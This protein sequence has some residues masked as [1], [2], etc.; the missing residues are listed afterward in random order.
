M[1]EKKLIN[2]DEGS[3]ILPAHKS[4]RLAFDNMEKG[5]SNSTLFSD[6][7]HALFRPV[8]SV[9]LRAFTETSF[10]F[11]MSCSVLMMKQEDAW[12]PLMGKTGAA[13]IG[14]MYG[15]GRFISQNLDRICGHLAWPEEYKF[16][17]PSMEDFPV[18]VADESKDDINSFTIPYMAL[19]EEVDELPDAPSKVNKRLKC[20]LFHPIGCQSKVVPDAT[21]TTHSVCGAEQDR[22]WKSHTDE[23]TAILRSAGPGW[24]YRQYEL[25]NGPQLGPHQC[26]YI[27]SVPLSHS[28]FDIESAPMIKRR[29]KEKAQRSYSGETCVADRPPKVQQ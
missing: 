22:Y 19:H 28:W 21:P 5:V 25:G 24:S 15:L 1:A 3:Y 11:D 6:L 9:T 27:P 17:I 16:L 10:K 29:E 18:E 23:G 20:A 4:I 8:P 2:R 26:S 13:T 12:M 7:S 14:T